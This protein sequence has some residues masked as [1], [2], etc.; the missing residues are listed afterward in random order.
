MTAAEA[1]FV[2]RRSG[3]VGRYIH[4]MAPCWTESAATS[5]LQ[6]R[7]VNDFA[8]VNNKRLF[9]RMLLQFQ[10]V[11]DEEWTDDV[12]TKLS[13]PVDEAIR[14]LMPPRQLHTS[15]SR[16]K[17][18]A[19]LDALVAHGVLIRLG[20]SVQFLLPVVAWQLHAL[21]MV[22]EDMPAIQ[23]LQVVRRKWTN[24]SPGAA[25]EGLVA[26][27]ALTEE[28]GARCRRAI[29]EV[30][31]QQGLLRTSDGAPL[32]RQN[33]AE[34]LFKMKADTGIDMWWVSADERGDSRQMWLNVVQVK[35][36]HDGA[37][38][39]QKG[40][41]DSQ[42][43]KFQQGARNDQSIAAC[44]ARLERGLK[45]LMPPLETLYHPAT[46]RVNPYL[47]ATRQLAPPSHSRRVGGHR[48]KP[49]DVGPDAEWCRCHGTKHHRSSH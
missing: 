31:V 16:T 18:E 24:G 20:V 23:A 21:L 36:S 44:I 26:K 39:M 12:M 8:S 42:R 14:A 32:Q 45:V 33:C 3:G 37:P 30:S 29:V 15:D 34:E 9:S 4:N 5:R 46:I 19:Q 6:Q 25:C 2:F 47:V 38:P 48:D 28:I 40:V 41:I 49:F 27:H 35:T 22:V 1:A 13:L 10:E 11:S 17:A 7:A 43:A